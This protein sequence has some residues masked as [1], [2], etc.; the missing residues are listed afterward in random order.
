MNIKK[1]IFFIEKITLIIGTKV[2]WLIF[3][4]ALTACTV[5]FLRYFFNIGFV[6]MQ[7][8]YVW[9]NGIVFLLGASFTLLYDQHVRVDIFYRNFSEKKK[10]TIN[11]LFSI[12]LILPFIYIVSKYSMP[13]VVKSWIS[14]ERSREAGGLKFLY[15]YKTFIILFCFFLF[16]Q[17]IALILRCIL[18]INQKEK[19]IFFKF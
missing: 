9:M 7:E 13:Y 10:A 12:F 6:W 1:I 8:S 17:T 4:M 5:A 11:I 16:I 18:V 14:L 3:I 2:S 19:E 15:L